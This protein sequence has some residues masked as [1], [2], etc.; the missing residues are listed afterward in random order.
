MKYSS[1]LNKIHQLDKTTLDKRSVS[2]IIWRKPF[3]PF[4][5]FILYELGKLNF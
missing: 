1:K 4:F 5:D 3:C 2:A